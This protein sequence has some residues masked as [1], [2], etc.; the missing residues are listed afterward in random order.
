MLLGK[1]TLKKTTQKA[2]FHAKETLWKQAKK[3][4]QPVTE[5]NLLIAVCVQMAQFSLMCKLKELWLKQM[6]AR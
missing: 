6:E 4:L 1:K 3:F 2:A 5:A